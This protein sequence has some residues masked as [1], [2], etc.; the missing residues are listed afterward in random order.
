MGIQIPA[1]WKHPPKPKV[2]SLSTAPE[3]EILKE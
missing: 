2:I 3:Q 1:L